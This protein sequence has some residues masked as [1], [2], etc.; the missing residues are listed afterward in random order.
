MKRGKLGP[1]LGKTRV[2]NLFFSC[3]KKKYTIFSEESEPEVKPAKRSRVPS[4]GSDNSEAPR[5]SRRISTEAEKKTKRTLFQEDVPKKT[6]KSDPPVRRSR[7]NSREPSVEETPSKTLARA[8]DKDLHI[9]SP[10][11]T[12]RRRTTVRL[13]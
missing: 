8:L 10:K 4:S 9:K 1:N 13:W 3:D 6:K 11:K 12:T 2:P 7:R 5:R